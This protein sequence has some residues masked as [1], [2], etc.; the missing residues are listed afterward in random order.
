[1]WL[2]ACLLLSLLCATLSAAAFTNCECGVEGAKSKFS[3]HVYHDHNGTKWYAH[4][5]KNTVLNFSSSLSH[6]SYEYF[7]PHLLQQH[8]CHVLQRGSSPPEADVYVIPYYPLIGKLGR[9]NVEYGK[10]TAYVLKTFG[11][12]P[13]SKRFNGLDHFIV[14]QW[15]I[16]GGMHNPWPLM[17]YIAHEIQSYGFGVDPT[18]KQSSV[19]AKLQNNIA[20]PYVTSIHNSVEQDL[21]PLPRSIIS[22]FVGS[23]VS[24]E[25]AKALRLTLE[26]YSRK[27]KDAV[28]ISVSRSDANPDIEK[29]Y[30]TSVFGFS[31]EGD[32]ESAR[33]TFSL[34]EAG[35]IPVIVCDYCIMPYE[36]ILNWRDFAV[37]MNS[38]FIAQTDPIQYLKNISAASVKQMQDNL[39]V[40][41]HVLSYNNPIRPGD[42]I[43][44]LVAAFRN[45]G[46]RIKRFKRWFVDHP[47][48]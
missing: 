2:P 35:V 37:F 46:C 22:V 11:S 36:D 5:A 20:V 28:W 27:H 33:R 3:F 24:R 48:A 32:T 39:A 30:R 43:D 14:N 4:S 16:D 1:M 17:S 23:I 6:F 21:P 38:S 9:H 45:H 25:S 47:V 34:I 40:A 19:L 7:I 10:T 15:Y 42:A 26:S 18:F 13:T 12:L 41:R 31:P 29:L 8:P 44:S